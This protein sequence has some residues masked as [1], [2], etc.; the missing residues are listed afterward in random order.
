MF[1]VGNAYKTIDGHYVH[2]IGK[3]KERDVIWLVGYY[4]LAGLGEIVVQRWREDNGQVPANVHTKKSLVEPTLTLNLTPKE[5]GVLRSLILY[6]TAGPVSG[7]R[8]LLLSISDKIGY[9]EV[10]LGDLPSFGINTTIRLADE[11][12]TE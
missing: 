5:A 11:G 9:S 12:D 4:A 3:V 6:H 8:G 2:L 10:P 7:P 1:K